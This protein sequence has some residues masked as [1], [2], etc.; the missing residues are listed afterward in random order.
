MEQRLIYEAVGYVSLDSDME[1]GEIYFTNEEA[2]I[3]YISKYLGG[4]GYARPRFANVKKVYKSLQDYENDTE[5][6]EELE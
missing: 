1:K 3:Q 6:Q 4:Q 2:T 5:N